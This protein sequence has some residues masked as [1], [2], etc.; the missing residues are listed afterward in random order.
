MPDREENLFQLDAF[1]LLDID[2]ALTVLGGDEQVLKTILTAMVDQENPEDICLLNTAHAS[3]DW[4]TI[5]RLT[6]RMKGGFVY[7]GTVRLIYACQYLERY[8]KMGDT[9]LLEPL[10]QQFLLVI[11]DTAVAVK[12]WLSQN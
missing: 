9:Q 3:G 12:Q 5:E 6:H 2:K 7:C 10:Y 4:D 1:P 8:R 11:E